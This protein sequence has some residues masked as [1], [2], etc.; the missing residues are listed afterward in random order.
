MA[1][2]RK[3]HASLAF[4]IPSGFTAIPVKF[5]LT[6]KSHHYLYV[7][8]HR[9][10]SENNTRRPLDRTLFVLNIPPYC[11]EEC[12]YRI[13]SPCGLI[14]SIELKEKPGP[15]EEP[16][17][18][19]A[20]SK[21]FRT[22]SSKGF[23]VAYVVF[24]KASSVTAAKK[25]RPKEAIVLSTEKQPIKTGLQRWVAQYSSASLLQADELQAEVDAFMQ[26]HDKRVAEESAR[27]AEGDGVP[28][29]EGWVKVTRG[30]RRPALPRT[31]AA[32]LRA[33]EAERRRR[34]KKELLNFYTWQHRES[35]REHIAELRK[36]FEEDKQRIAMMREQ[37]K[38]K[39]Y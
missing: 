29:G 9:V 39:P 4:E 13:L 5:Q 1:P 24:K 6:S 37:R 27:L 25:L 3:Q 11:P 31:E 12:L 2:T 7:K 17:P 38:F 20:P 10:R 15:E 16:E 23:L 33:V 26:A 32:N 21:H 8:E 36:K 19:P 18:E 22:Q 30:G 14:Q 35:K 28:D 34:A